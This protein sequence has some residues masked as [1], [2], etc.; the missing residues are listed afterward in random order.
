MPYE[1]RGCNA[2]FSAPHDQ[3][4]KQMSLSLQ[5]IIEIAKV[6][7]IVAWKTIWHLCLFF[8][9]LRKYWHQRIG[10]KLIKIILLVIFWRH[11]EFRLFV[12]KIRL[13]IFT[14]NAYILYKYWVVKGLSTVYGIKNLLI[15]Y[16]MFMFD[17]NLYTYI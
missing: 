16:L 8:W 7:H 14:L 5:N 12:Q 9:S 13:F 17:K 2:V 4:V 1:H 3:T 6:M 11:L 15:L 10:P